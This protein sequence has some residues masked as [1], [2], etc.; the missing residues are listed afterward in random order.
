MSRLLYCPRCGYDL[1]GVA[2]WTDACPLTGVCSECGH[3]FA[4]VDIHDPDRSHLAGFV[5]HATT[6]RRLVTWSFRT[7]FW[8]LYPFAFWRRVTLDQRI[9]VRGMIAWVLVLGVA[10]SVL[11]G[12]LLTLRLV[13][14]QRTPWLRPEFGDFLM[15]WVPGVRVRSWGDVEPSLEFL[16]L[17]SALVLAHLSFAVM[18]LGLSESRKIA[19]LRPIHIVRAFVYGLAVLAPVVVLSLVRQFLMVFGGIARIFWRPPPMAQ[20][21]DSI[22]TVIGGVFLALAT[23]YIGV[24]WYAAIVRVWRLHRAR[25]V[26]GLLATIGALIGLLSAIAFVAPRTEFFSRF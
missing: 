19:A 7:L 21:D 16:G 13:L 8:A 15:A 12:L 14:H 9:V 2:T 25:V 10:S 18:I 1:S 3:P 4:W 20:L 23:L 17:L 5:E 22:I 26:F 24:W 11:S 6:R